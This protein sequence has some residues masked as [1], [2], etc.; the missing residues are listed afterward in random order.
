M[1]VKKVKKLWK[2]RFVSVRDYEIE[3]GITEGGMCIKHN[4]EQMELTPDELVALRPTG[5]YLQ[6]KFSGQ[7][8]LADIEWKPSN[9]QEGLFE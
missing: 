5:P 7:Y 9:S 4:G 2:G 8:R 3:M 6:S 1:I